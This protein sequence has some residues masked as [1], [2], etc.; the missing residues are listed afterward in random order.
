[1]MLFLADVRVKENRKILL[2]KRSGG[3]RE[4]RGSEDPPL[5]GAMRV[6]VEAF[7]VEEEEEDAGAEGEE[8]AGK[9]ETRN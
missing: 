4:N 6:G 5:Q 2:C 3:E 7:F 1:M 8:R 9:I